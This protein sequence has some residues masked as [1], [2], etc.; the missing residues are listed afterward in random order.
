MFDATDEPVDR[1][2]DVTPKRLAR[3]VRKRV[4]LGVGLIVLSLGGWWTCR[5]RV[6]DRPLRPD[7]GDAEEP[8]PSP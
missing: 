5:G 7:H 4:V 8:R 6:D 3:G 1:V 2:E